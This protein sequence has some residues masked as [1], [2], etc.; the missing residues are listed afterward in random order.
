MVYD[1]V[2]VGGGLS[3]G[4]ALLALLAQRPGA[5]VALIE[6]DAQLGGNHT[7]CFHA[8]D[9]PSAARSWLQALVVQ[10]WP[11]YHVRFPRRVR[12]VASPYACVSSTRLAQVIE[13]RCAGRTEVALRLGVDAVDVRADAVQLSDGS[14]VRGTLIIDARGPRSTAAPGCQKFLGLELEVEPGHALREPTIIDATV[15]QRDGLRFMY[16][17]PLLPDRVLIEDTYFSE[18]WSLDDEH[19]EREVLSYATRCGLRVRKILRRERGVLPMPSAGV[20][21]RVDASPI[22]AG[23]AGGYFHPT[24]GYSFPLAVRFAQALAHT[25]P[26]SLPGSALANFAAAHAA[27]LPFLFGLTH[28]MFAWFAPEQRF[29]VLEHFYR[30]PEPVLARFYAAQLS[31]FDKLRVLLGPIP[32]GLSLARMARF[33]QGAAA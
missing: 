9:V 4:L 5:T 11:A 25:D 19:I 12:R 7:W 33:S 28:V 24:T 2:L 27:Q 17:L 26:R 18:S 32:S 3:S 31:T 10:R 22:V 13:A 14:C 21:P 15:P 6:R 29:S 23:Y 1:F 30:L 20:L 16:A 8:G